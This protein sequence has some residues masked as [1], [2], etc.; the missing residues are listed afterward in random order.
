VFPSELDTDECR[1]AWDRWLAYKRKK[2][3]AYKSPDT[4]RQ[5]LLSAAPHGAEAFVKSLETAIRNNW[6]GFFPEKFTRAGNLDF[7]ERKAARQA[8]V[9]ERAQALR[10]AQERLISA[11]PKLEA[12]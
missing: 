3:Q 10:D 7:Q 1:A 8:D 12:K 6:A 11:R 4:Q 5:A 9:V 2:G